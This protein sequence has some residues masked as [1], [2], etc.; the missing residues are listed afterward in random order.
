MLA[1]SSI[2]AASN[3]TRSPAA[4]SASA[5]CCGRVAIGPGVAEEDVVCSGGRVGNTQSIHNMIAKC[6]GFCRS[7]ECYPWLCCRAGGTLRLVPINAVVRSF[8]R[9]M[10]IRR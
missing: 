3:H 8:D 7:S 6:R 10:E 2:S 4:V 5:I 9:T 1:K